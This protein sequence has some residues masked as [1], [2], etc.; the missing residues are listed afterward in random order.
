MMRWESRRV[1]CECPPAVTPEV[2]EV[3]SQREGDGRQRCQPALEAAWCADAE[4]PHQEPEIEAAAVHE[5]PFRD[6]RVSPQMDTPH[7]TGAVK[8][9]IRAFPVARFDVV[10]TRARACPECVGGCRTPRR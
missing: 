6:V 10:A 3:R 2:D 7:P 5:E 8:M 9:R 1:V 4:G